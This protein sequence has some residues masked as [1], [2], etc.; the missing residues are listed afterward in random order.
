MFEDIADIDAKVPASFIDS[1]P[2]PAEE[3]ARFKK[4]AKMGLTYREFDALLEQSEYTPVIVTYD[5]QVNHRMSQEAIN[6]LLAQAAKDLQGGMMAK[7]VGLLLMKGV[8]L[9]AKAQSGGLL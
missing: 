6:G 8:A 4:Y 7:E 2:L 5:I 1:L 3:K 9:Y